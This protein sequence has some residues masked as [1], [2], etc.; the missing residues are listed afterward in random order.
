MAFTT[1][2]FVRTYGAASIPSMNSRTCDAASS[3]SVIGKPFSIA[4]RS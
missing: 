2:V 3:T 1:R 4:S